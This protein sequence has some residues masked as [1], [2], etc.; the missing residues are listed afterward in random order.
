LGGLIWDPVQN[1]L[2]ALEARRHGYQAGVDG[3]EYQRGRQ[4]GA[5]LRL[6]TYVMQKGWFLPDYGWFLP[7]FRDIR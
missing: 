7:N 4:Q 2:G 6:S 5:G 3:C 1:L